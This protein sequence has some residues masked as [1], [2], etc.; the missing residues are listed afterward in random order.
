MIRIEVDFQPHPLERQAVEETKEDIRNRLNGHEFGP[1][2]I[3]LA[4][5]PGSR[6]FALRFLG[7]PESC[8]KARRLLGFY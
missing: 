1:F 5:S 3:V 2:K 8:D 7:D 6:Q 4:R